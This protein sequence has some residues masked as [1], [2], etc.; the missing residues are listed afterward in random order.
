MK[1]NQITSLMATL[2]NEKFWSLT[3]SESLTQSYAVLVRQSE[4]AATPPRLTSGVWG[5]GSGSTLVGVGSE[6]PPEFL[7]EYSGMFVQPTHLAVR[8]P[9]AWYTSPLAS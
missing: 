7:K 2:L 1:P 8:Q 4:L 9:G 5:A 3:R 6:D